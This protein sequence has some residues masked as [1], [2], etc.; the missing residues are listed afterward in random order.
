M[1][2]DRDLSGIQNL[3]ERNKKFYAG[4]QKREDLLTQ[5]INAV[6]LRQNT[7][8]LLCVLLR[9]QLNLSKSPNPVNE[10]VALVINY[11]LAKYIC[12]Y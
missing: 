12:K 2:F 3:Y 8:L 9:N 1:I 10:M 4:F 6:D 5:I 11:R 7:P